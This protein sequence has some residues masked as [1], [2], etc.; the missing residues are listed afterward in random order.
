MP[1]ILESVALANERMEEIVQTALVGPQRRLGVSRSQR[2]CMES[3]IAA[4]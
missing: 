3:G 2:M 4:R 1:P